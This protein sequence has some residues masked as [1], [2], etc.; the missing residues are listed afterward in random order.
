MSGSKWK[1]SFGPRCFLL[2]LI[3]LATLL[4]VSGGSV[5]GLAH[6]AES[7][8]VVGSDTSTIRNPVNY[9]KPNQSR[10]WYNSHKMRWD[11]LVP[12]NDG[13]ADSQS[14]HYILKAV[15]GNQ[16]FTTVELEDRDFGRPDCFWDDAGKKLY[17]L[18]SHPAKSEFWRLGYDASTD[19]Y[20]IE[21]GTPGEGIG[22]PGIPEIP[23][24]PEM[25]FTHP[26][27]DVG[28]D[29][30]ATLYVSPNG[31]VWV[32]VMKDSAVMKNSK[33]LEVQ[34]FSNNSW[35]S[36][37]VILDRNAKLGVTTWTH[38]E[39]QGSTYVGLFAGE[40]G[41]DGTTTL[42]SFRYIEQDADP[43][44]LSNWINE[45]KNI[46]G[47]FGNEKS[48]D[49][50]SSARD[51]AGNMYFAV[52][53]EGGN[54]PDPLIKLYKRTP[55]GTWSQFTVTKTVEKPEQSR[56]SIVID[57]YDNIYI[58]TNGA[59][60]AGSAERK[61]VRKKISL[62]ALEDLADAPSTIL[63]SKDNTVFTDII[64]PRQLVNEESGIVVLA[65][66]RTDGTVWFSYEDVGQPVTV[67]V[68][69]V[70][71]LLQTDAESEILAAGLKVGTITE[72]NSYT[73][74]KGLI[75]SQN[76]TAGSAVPEGTAVNL[77]V[78]LGPGTVS[79]ITVFVDQDSWLK[80]A[81]PFDNF[82]SEKEL[83]VKNK[84]GDSER[85]VFRFD[86]SGIPA[87]SKI[88]AAT[89]TF[90]VTTPDTSPI[91]IYRITDDWT[92]FGVNWRNTAKDF[93]KSTIHGSFRPYR[94]DAFV[95]VDLT[96][97]VQ[98]WVCGTPNQGV[99]FIATSKDKQSK[100]HSKNIDNSSYRPSMKVVVGAEPSPC[101]SPL[102]GRDGLR[103]V[104]YEL[105][106]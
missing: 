40:N 56:P 35:L 83:P 74:P 46:P 68:P 69:D 28:G 45:S 6:A 95:S 54:G 12:K 21:I 98:A 79:V 22:I 50:V 23:E 55:E 30:P 29:S 70:A 52:K 34:R 1:V 82:G 51:K 10:I 81:A 105:L 11:A 9:G 8:E 106:R 72:Q 41:E 20:R 101:S 37:P 39:Y 25:W 64:A 63:F 32:A 38:F 43:S 19:S 84:R 53:T 104:E 5:G 94:D 87:N 66:N 13:H 86:L 59:E 75:I 14:D 17:V 96:P 16:N 27:T 31:H 93:D 26:N 36:S 85:A 57:E 99:M 73:V 49:H 60:S 33:G 24:I 67:E 4:A 78:S 2:P 89:A 58:Y 62:S 92:E 61:A 71:G 100:Y 48:D 18:S 97:L 91:N 44:D 15:D 88:D 103:R 42:F 77:V 47:P 90:R 102:T 3:V 76:P 7:S 65:H 80:E